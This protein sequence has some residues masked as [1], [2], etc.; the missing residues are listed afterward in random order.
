[1]ENRELLK[2]ILQLPLRKWIVTEY[3]TF[4]DVHKTMMLFYDESDYIKDL[5]KYILEN[6]KTFKT[7]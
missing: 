4:Q 7:K 1:M 3:G 5:Y 6:Y 2:Q